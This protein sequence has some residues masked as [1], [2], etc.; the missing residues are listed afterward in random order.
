M[1]IKI[2]KDRLGLQELL[3]SQDITLICET[4]LPVG[5]A[6]RKPGFRTYNIRGPNPTYG[7]TAVLVRSNIPMLKSLQ[8]SA[9]SV[10][11]NGLETVIGAVYL[12]PSKP[13]EEDDLDT[14]IGLSKSKKFIFGGGLNGKKLIGTLG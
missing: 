12:S 3:H 2:S 1:K 8:A 14:L 11:L 4:K 6:W 5:F 13:F 7:G 10:E 9:I